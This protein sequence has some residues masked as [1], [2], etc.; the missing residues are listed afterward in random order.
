MAIRLSNPLSGKRPEKRNLDEQGIS[1]SPTVKVVTEQYDEGPVQTYSHLFLPIAPVVFPKLRILQGKKIENDDNFALT[2]I[3][4]MVREYGVSLSLVC[5]MPQP[6][7]QQR[8]I[9]KNLRSLLP[10]GPSKIR[11]LDK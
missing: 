1:P 3:D 9:Q 11:Q 7:G 6:R 4:N 8:E 10:H 2:V 5:V